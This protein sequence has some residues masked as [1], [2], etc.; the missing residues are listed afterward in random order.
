MREQKQRNDLITKLARTTA[1]LPIDCRA[2]CSARVTSPITSRP[3]ERSKTYAS[4]TACWLRAGVPMAKEKAARSRTEPGPSDCWKKA[5]D[6]E[7]RINGC[8]APALG[9]VS[10][11]YQSNDRSW[12]RADARW[13]SRPEIGLRNKDGGLPKWPASGRQRP[14]VCIGSSPT[15][16]PIAFA[17]AW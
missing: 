8:R 13:Q 10:H 6:S 1:R 14:V 17:V 12:R 7:Q 16:K 11:P 15:L 3:P 5:R 4:T 9:G 2:S